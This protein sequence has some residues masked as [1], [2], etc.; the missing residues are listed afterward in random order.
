[1]AARPEGVAWDPDGLLPPPAG[2]SHF[3]RRARQRAEATGVQL[4]QQGA[5]RPIPADHL[6]AGGLPAA[7]ASLYDRPAFQ[8]SCCCCCCCRCKCF[9]TA[10]SLSMYACLY[11]AYSAIACP[12][13][14]LFSTLLILPRAPHPCHALQSQL[15]ERNLPVDLDTPGLRILHFDPPIFALPD[16]F[17]GGWMA[18]GGWRLEAGT[19]RV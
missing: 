19:D 16:F 9:T 15:A 11:A 10:R 4:Q 18:A 17:T 3:A 7:D 2:E 12:G 14:N 5:T 13:M 1:V 6:A 8:A